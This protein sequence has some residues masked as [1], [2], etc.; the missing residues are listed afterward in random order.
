MQGG[1]TTKKSGPATM[2]A[3]QQANPAIAV[4]WCAAWSAPSVDGLISSTPK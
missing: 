3:D 1:V 4:G 2:P